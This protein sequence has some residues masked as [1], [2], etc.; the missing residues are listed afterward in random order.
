MCLLL[1]STE[2]EDFI[3][4]TP[5]EDIKKKMLIIVKSQIN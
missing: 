4:G 1:V 2:N 3:H 5:K